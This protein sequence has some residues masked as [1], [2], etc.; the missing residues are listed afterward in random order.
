MS[1]VVAIAFPITLLVAAAS[2]QC[3]FQTVAV[4]SHGA[5]CNEVVPVV[6]QLAAALDAGSCTLSLRVDADPGCC[7]SSVQ[8]YA[9]VV[10][11]QPANLPL[12]LSAPACRLLVQPD[13]FVAQAGPNANAFHFALPPAMPPVTFL[14]QGSALYRSTVTWPSTAFRVGLTPGYTVT[15]H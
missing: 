5:G 15:L 9:L 2:G 10:G 6:P 4:Q 13:L 12:P 8:A 11:S 3:A 14:V 1:P 7:N